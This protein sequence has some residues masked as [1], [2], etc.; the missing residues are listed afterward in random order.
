MEKSVEWSKL[1]IYGIPITP[2]SMDDGLFLLKEEIETFNLEV[3]LLKNPRW[4]SLKESRQNKKHAFITIIVENA[5]QAK[6]T[7][8]KK[9][10]YIAGSQLEVMKFKFN[11]INTQCQKC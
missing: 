2:F 3:K 10:L 1:V 11:T 5:E 9:F 7:L 6:A 8:Q 4:L